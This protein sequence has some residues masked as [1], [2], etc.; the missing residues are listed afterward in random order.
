MSKDT[1]AENPI[2]LKPLKWNQGGYDAIYVDRGNGLVRFL[3][4][5]RGA[6]HSLHLEYFASFF[7]GIQ[8]VQGLTFKV[9]KL[10]IFFLMPQ[11]NLGIFRFQNSDI[12][13]QGSLEEPLIADWG[14]KKDQE[15]K[16][17]QI[18]GIQGFDK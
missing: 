16:Q 11:K 10:E 2:W 13:G 15:F 17:I 14:W 3:Q 8:Q 18:R 1:F 6:T 5:T 9:K 7:Q 4:I 12:T